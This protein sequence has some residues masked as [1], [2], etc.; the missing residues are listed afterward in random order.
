MLSIQRAGLFDNLDQVNKEALIIYDFLKTD[1]R[2]NGHT[3][4]SLAKLK[5]KMENECRVF[6]EALKFLKRH[7]ITKEVEIDNDMKVCLQQLYNYERKI[8]EGINTLYK[9]QLEDPWELDVDLERF[10]ILDELIIS[11]TMDI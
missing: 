7:K 8:T 4:I 6:D 1:S 11:K 9:K 3:Q 5:M 10:V 2:Q